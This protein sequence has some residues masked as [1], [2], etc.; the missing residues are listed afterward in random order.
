LRRTMSGI[1]YC[2][3]IG[4]RVGKDMWKAGQCKRTVHTSSSGRICRSP[5]RAHPAAQ[6]DSSDAFVWYKKFADQ[7]AF[8]R[9]WTEAEDECG[10]HIAIS[11]MATA[12][13]SRDQD[14]TDANVENSLKRIQQRDNQSIQRST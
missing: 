5:T 14:Q 4:K 8:I 6:E 7:R 9:V 11:A 3:E 13:T 1:G 12:Q 10:R 2:D